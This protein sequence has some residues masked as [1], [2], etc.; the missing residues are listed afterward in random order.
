ITREA[1]NQYGSLEPVVRGIRAHRPLDLNARR[2]RQANPDGDFAT[3]RSAARNCLMTGLHYDPGALDLR[4]EVLSRV[5]RDDLIVEEVAF[6][7]TPWI[8]VNAN[9]LLP[10]RADGPV[11]GLVVFHAWGGPML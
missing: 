11:P 5:E 1:L 10:K 6:N 4:A 2:W 7:T 9:L 3:W 8:R